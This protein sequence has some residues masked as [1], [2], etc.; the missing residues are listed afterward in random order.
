MRYSLRLI[1]TFLLTGSL[2]TSLWAQADLARRKQYLEESL[3]LNVQQDHRHPISRRVT[4]QDST[5]LDWQRRTGEL[6]PDFSTLP[7][8]PFL[9]DPLLSGTTG[10]CIQ[11]AADWSQERNRI[12]REFQHWISG[13]VPPAP[14]SVKARM[15]SDRYEGTVRIQRI[16]LS[17]GP[18]NRARMT[19]ELMIPPGKGTLPVYMTPVTHRGWAQ[20]AVKRGY[21]GCVYAGADTQDD[22]QAYQTLYPDYDFTGLMRRAWGAS[23]VVDYLV[24][25]K[26]VNP[27]Q[28]AITGHSRN[29]KQALW[30][31][32][33]DERFAA[34]ISSSC[35]TGGITPWRFS[36]PQYGNQTIDDIC[37]NAAHWFHPRLRFF[38][39]RED[40]LPIDQNQ[41]LALIAPR[42][43]LLTYS[44]V[45]RQLNPWA[46]EQ[47]YQSAKTVYDFLKS[48]EKIGLLPRMGEHAVT[49][50]DVERCLDFLD[51]QFKRKTARWENVRY[52]DFSYHNWLQSTKTAR[53]SWPAIR[54]NEAKD[55]V[56]LGRQKQAIRARLNWL[57][58]DEPAGVKPNPVAPTTTDRVDWIDGITGRPKPKRT[59]ITYLGPYTA[60]GDHL[61]GTL[62]QPIDSLKPGKN[63]PVVIYLHSYNYNTGYAVGYK[64]EGGRGNEVLFQEVLDQG[65]AVLAIDLLGFGNRL[66]EGTYFYERFP[67]WSKMGKMVSD[68]RACVDALEAYEGLD[69]RQIYVLGETIGGSVALMAAALD[70]RIA[71]VAV[72][73]AFSPWRT[74]TKQYE[75]LKND[76]YQHGFLP[77]LGLFAENPQQTPV[78]Y[79]EIMACIAPRPLLV[80]SPSLNRH[81][82]PL[83]V[84]ATLERVK[85]VYG[86]YQKTDALQ[87]QTPPEINRITAPMRADL[88]RFLVQ[89]DK[90]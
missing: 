59:T 36:D 74:S 78:D 61:S 5:W 8:V 87:F 67:A 72:V 80:I 6:P 44:T 18:E 85:T 50:R 7:S 69:N 82:D 83:A 39:G 41:L 84:Q 23:R 76:A 2:A 65:F 64:P 51:N 46:N 89:S 30:A 47:C 22:T 49:T 24:T 70:Q 81:A 13:T 28:I 45:E 25:R 90:P 68:V 9:P 52:C 88:T 1:L 34:V 77:R 14:A 58:G 38:F 37:A 33:F 32:A 55:T 71:G 48:P 42:S 4:V 66:E 31:A 40:R 86:M 75:S 10:K 35:G 29:G 27:A 63:R 15:L 19:L 62:Y 16:E 3:R 11:T 60:M 21:I 54:L 57:L 20:L 17:F 73:A 12:R 26:E 43:L 56:A 53:P 79:D